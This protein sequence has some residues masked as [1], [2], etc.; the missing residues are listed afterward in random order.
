MTV[1]KDSILEA[2]VVDL[3]KIIRNGHQRFL[4][5]TS[6]GA[7]FSLNTTDGVDVWRLEMDEDEL[8]SHRELSETSSLEAFLLKIR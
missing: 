3:H 5:Y 8:E 6:M 4:C 7:S 1:Y 2:K